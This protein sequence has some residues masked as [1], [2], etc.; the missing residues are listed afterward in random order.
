M[1]NAILVEELRNT[2]SALRKAQRHVALF[3]LTAS[4]VN[5]SIAQN[6]IVST[7]GYDRMPTKKALIDAINLLKS[8]LSES[9]L[10]QLGRLTVLKTQDPF[11]KAIN[12]AFNV[13]NSTVSL[14]SCNIFGIHI[15]NAV[16]LESVFLPPKQIKSAKKK[17]TKKKKTVKTA[18][19]TK[20][21]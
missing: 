13:R 16:I 6:L 7:K 12:Q 5:V 21:K 4:E 9:S 3:M 14:Q 17:P 15:E 1:D 8:K 19:N 2:I 18:K 10:K 11:V 20:E